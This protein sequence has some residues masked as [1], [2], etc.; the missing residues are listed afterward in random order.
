MIVYFDCFAG[1]A[2][3]MIVGALLDAGADFAALKAALAGVTASGYDL[4]AEKVNRGGLVGSKFH[5]DLHTDDHDHKHDHHDDHGHH[6]HR[7][8]T[9]ILAMI[10]AAG[11]PPR[12]AARAADIFRRLGAAEAKVHGVPVEQVHFHEVGAI[13]SIMDIVGA[14]VAM[15]LLNIDR[16]LC[17]PIPTGSGTVQTAH[18]LLPVP[19]PATAEL[20]VGCVTTAGGPTGECTTPT[21]AAILSTL[22]EGYGPLPAMRVA[23]VGYGAGSRTDGPGPNLL[24]AF[25]GEAYDDGGVD[26]VVELSANIDDC[27]GEIIGSTI[28]LLLEAGCLDA[29]ATPAVMKKSRPAWVL[30]ALC[31]PAD[32]DAAESVMFRQTTTFGIRRR[33]CGRTKL[34]RRHETVETMYGPIRVKIGSREGQVITVSPEFADCAEAAKSHHASVREVMAA[35]Q[36]AWGARNST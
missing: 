14:C 20:L 19:A 17:S 29:W 25:V 28:G 7:G 31:L 6:H 30:S 10:D 16:L 35:A 12:A 13:D 26:S 5:V 4:R 34:L 21:A 1:A 27:S 18:G 32:V 11:L 2:G 33:A 36:A 24:R 15:E 8:L 3:D 23:K 22:A 9:E